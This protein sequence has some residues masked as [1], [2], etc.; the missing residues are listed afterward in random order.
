MAA[1]L[2][3]RTTRAAGWSRRF[4]AFSAALLI[5]ATL[6]HRYGLLET[7]A[8]IWVLGIVFVCAIF[9]LMMGTYAFA[10]LWN[11]GDLGGRD[12][13]FGV[14]MGLV[15]LVPFL[16][17]AYQ[18]YTSPMLNDISTDLEDP[19]ALERAAALRTPDM[20][21]IQ[22]MTPARARLQAQAY[23]TVTGR[24][25]DLDFDRTLDAV[26]AVVKRQGWIVHPGVPEEFAVSE[27]TI[28]ALAYT[29]VFA[30]PIDVAVRVTDEGETTYVDMRSTSRYGQYDFGDNAARIVAFLGELDTEIAGQAGTAPTVPIP[31]PA[32]AQ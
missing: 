12:L 9:A 2:E 29:T 8:L 18:G 15:V 31:Q 6:S 25:Y 13:S 24:R 32:P 30:F 10:R 16:I 17:T 19:P 20:N 11:H 14:I 1:I 27:T 23:P 22:P 21:R 3:Q 5:V 4:G 28:E 7:P 26:S